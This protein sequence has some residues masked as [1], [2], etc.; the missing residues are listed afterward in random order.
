[1]KFILCALFSIV[2]T[3]RSNAQISF[4]DTNIVYRKAVMDNLQKSILNCK[5]H[6]LN[7]D[8]KNIYIINSSSVQD[9]RT[10]DFVIKNITSYNSFGSMYDGNNKTVEFHLI[11]ESF[12]LSDTA[13]E[14]EMYLKYK[15]FVSEMVRI[16]DSV[17]FVNLEFYDKKTYRS[18]FINEFVVFDEK[19]IVFDNILFFINPMIFRNKGI[20]N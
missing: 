11:K 5:Q 2:F 3:Y 17:M 9:E 14:N 15:K 19:G 8:L 12:N 20:F 13:A 18:F 7:I 1:M 4:I 6:T 16:N 10:R